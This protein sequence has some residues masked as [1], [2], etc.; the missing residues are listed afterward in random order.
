MLSFSPYARIN[1]VPPSE[2]LECALYVMYR[3]GYIRCFR[4]DNGR[5]F[6][7][8]A[9]ELV[10]PCALH[11]VARGC[12][13]MFNPP[14]SPKKN[15]K[16]ERNQGT[17]ARWA[18][19]EQCADIDEFRRNLEYAIEAQRQRLPTRVCQGLSR[20]DYYPGLFR[21]ARRYDPTDFDR[22]RIYAYLAQ[23]KWYRKV[24]TVGQLSM[25][26]K[27]YQVG[28]PHKSKTFTATLEMETQKPFWC[29]RDET[30]TLIA[31]RYAANIDDGSFWNLS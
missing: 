22:Q 7:D 15:A 3:W 21:N 17:T 25:F 31:K 24:S 28:L 4:F 27:T 18:D 26:G 2:V 6:G 16:V 13:V 5:P 10:S 14:R 23:G 29:F 11:L 30:Q 1:E 12:E 19:I 20:A 8:P 9:R